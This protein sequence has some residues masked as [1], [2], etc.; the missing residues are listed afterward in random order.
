MRAMAEKCGMHM[1]LEVNGRV[2]VRLP[3][4]KHASSIWLMAQAWAQ[5]KMQRTL[6][7]G[8]TGSSSWCCL[9]I[10]REWSE[11]GAEAMSGSGGFDT[12][13]REHVDAS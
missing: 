12:I 6:F 7:E 10:C 9:P 3:R 8:A 4:G 13:T 5:A 11:R 2:K 1:S